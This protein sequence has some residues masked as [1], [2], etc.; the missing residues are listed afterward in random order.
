[1]MLWFERLSR[2]F[3]GY[4]TTRSERDPGQSAR[5][6]GVYLRADQGDLE[7]LESGGEQE[8]AELIAQ[9]LEE[10]K[11]AANAF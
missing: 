9:R 8:R 7:L 11:S 6:S 4:W 10:W 3:G 2:R 1:M 5:T